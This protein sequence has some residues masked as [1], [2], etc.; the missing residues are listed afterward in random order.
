MMTANE[1]DIQNLHDEA[2]RRAEHSY[3]DPQTGY[4]VFTELY[5]LARGFCCRSNCRHCPYDLQ[6]ECKEES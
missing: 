6:A 5:H 3:I 2:V 1:K 4:L